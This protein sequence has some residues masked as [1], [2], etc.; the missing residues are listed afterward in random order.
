MRKI[1]Y[2]RVQQLVKQLPAA[3]L[4]RV[5]TMLLKIT[6]TEPD[7][8]SPQVDFMNLPLAQRRKIM[9]KQ[10]QQAAVYYNQTAAERE[11]WQGF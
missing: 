10:A 4:Q 5:Y 8:E 2:N 3:K 1:T 6:E 11:E 7:N 9:K